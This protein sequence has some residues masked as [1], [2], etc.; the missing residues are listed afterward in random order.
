[1]HLHLIL[2]SDPFP[3]TAKPLAK[4]MTSRLAQLQGQF[5]GLSGTLPTT[6]PGGVMD[7]H[8]WS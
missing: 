4:A 3:C 5:A 7:D 2:K 1:M 8:V 6:Q